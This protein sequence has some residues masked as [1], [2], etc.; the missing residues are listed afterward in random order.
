MSCIGCSVGTNADGTPKGCKSNG[1]CSTGGCNKLNTYDWL[2]KLDLPDYSDYGYVEVSFKNGARKS[3]FQH[4][5]H[6]TYAVTGDMVVVDNG[7]GSDIGKISLSG[8]LVRLQMKK[9][10]VKEDSILLKVIRK[11]NQRDLEKLQEARDKEPEVMVKA[12]VIARKLKL[13]MKIGDVEFQGDKRK[14]TFYY[15]A[16]GRVDFRELIRQYAKEFRVKIEM[17]QIG[18]RQESARI[19]GIGSCGRELCCSTWLSDFRSVSTAAARYQNLAINQT[20]LSGQCGRLKCCLNYELDTYM[21]ALS[22]FP[23]GVDTLHTEAGKAVLVKTDIFKRTMYF[24][25]LSDKGG[26]GKFYPLDL[27]RVKEI[28]E[29]NK[30]GE[31]P[32]ELLSDAGKYGMLDDDDVPASVEFGDDEGLTGV[33]ELPPEERR[34]KKKNRNKKRRPQQNKSN[35]GGKSQQRNKTSNKSGGTKS[36]Q[37]KSKSDKPNSNARK[38]NDGKN[39][40]RPSNKNRNK[41]RKNKNRNNK[42][43]NTSDNKTNDNKNSDK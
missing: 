1:G 4:T 39:K 36:N 15:T 24:A 16:D 12:R 6:T 29:M 19:G 7:G 21:D 27:E 13:D 42:P 22:A 10:R 5:P 18:A 43:D 37:P 28:R 41:N 33:I 34:R 23:K 20:K 9:K 26:R 31:K 3:F 30:N 32:A 8:D 17:R 38:A 14:I 11:A 25:Y 2:S 35:R 40:P